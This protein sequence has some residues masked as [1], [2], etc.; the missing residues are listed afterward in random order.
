[1]ACGQQETPISEENRMRSSLSRSAALAMAAWILSAGIAD[2]AEANLLRNGGFENDLAP[3]WEKRTPE[4]PE[5][6]LTRTDEVARSGQWSLRLEGMAAGATRLRQGHD[7]SIRIEPGSQV[8]LSAWVKSD[9]GPSGSATLQLYCKDAA[10]KILAQP[11]SAAVDGRKDW[12][13]MRLLAGV[14]AGTSHARHLDDARLDGVDQGEVG[15][16]PREQR[17]LAVARATQEQGR[18]RK[19]VHRPDNHLPHRWRV[20]LFQRLLLPP[21]RLPTTPNHPTVRWYG[22][23]D[24]SLGEP[25]RPSGRLPV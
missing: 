3:V 18:R 7:Q 24:P 21:L 20:S 9:L 16:H 17:A 6:S 11:K 4:S 13:Q 10:G 19:V 14:P 2:A 5:R 1:V 8:E 22:P 25:Q 23:D 12:P 15:D